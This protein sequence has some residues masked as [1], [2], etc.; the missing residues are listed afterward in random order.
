MINKDRGVIKWDSI[1]L[2]EHVEM[3]KEVF[4][5]EEKKEKPILDEQQTIEINATLKHALQEDLSVRILYFYEHD[6]HTIEGKML[7]TDMMSGFLVMD[8]ETM[9]R[10]QFDDILDVTIM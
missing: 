5:E 4:R 7:N 6:E 8:N 9:T 1:M 3:L 10:I 2:P